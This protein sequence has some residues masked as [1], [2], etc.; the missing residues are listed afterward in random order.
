[1]HFIAVRV[2]ICTQTYHRTCEI[3]VYFFLDEPLL[4]GFKRDG[5]NVDTKFHFHILPVAALKGMGVDRGAFLTSGGG[6]GHLQHLVRTLV[7][8]WPGGGG[9]LETLPL[10]LENF[11]ICSP[12]P[13]LQHFW[14]SYIMWLC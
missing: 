4:P 5:N 13:L 6:F 8:M 3:S 12:H 10:K 1:M 7:G 11:V 2:I 14:C 9:C